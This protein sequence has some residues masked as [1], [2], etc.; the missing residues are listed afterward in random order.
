MKNWTL[1]ILSL[2]LSTLVAAAPSDRDILEETIYQD[3]KKIVQANNDLKLNSNS[4][5]T[6]FEQKLFVDA[7]WD[8]LEEGS[9]QALASLDQLNTVNYDL[10]EK[11]RV[12]ILKIKNKRIKSLS[13]DLT[14][15]LKN[16]LKSP[17]VDVKIIYLIAAYEKDLLKAG[18]KEIVN[19]AKKH[20]EYDDVSDSEYS[21]DDMTNEMVSDIFHKSPSTITYMNGEYI[22]SVKIFKFCRQNRLFPC[23]MVMK[24]VNGEVVRNADGS[25]WTHKSL[26]ASKRGLPSYT[27]NGNTPAGIYTID[28]VMPVA[29]EQQSFGKYR[30][31]ILNFIPKSKNEVLLKKL[32][33]ESSVDHDWW[34]PS[35]TGR[36]IGR[37]LFRIHGT[38]NINNDPNVPYYPF[39]RTSGCIAQRENTY[40]GVTYQDQRDLLDAIMTSLELTPTYENELKVKGILYL[41]EIDNVNSAVEAGDLEIRG[42]E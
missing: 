23:L 22:R 4:G 1:I 30:R 31:M 25:I 27:K 13:K 34:M 8:S 36:D 29:D 9:I 5:F 24:D 10:A 16:A 39:V 20:P 37:N 6:N 11:L 15:E 3:Y 33:P 40:D 2:L 38:Q 42:I 14:T 28:S 17:K 21:K 26:A 41:V 35:V 19:L 7:L 12:A 18:G 32:L